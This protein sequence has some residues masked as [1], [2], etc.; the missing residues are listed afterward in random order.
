MYQVK[1]LVQREGLASSSHLLDLTQAMERK[2]TVKRAKEFLE[3]LVTEHWLSVVS[4][5]WNPSLP[6]RDT[7]TLNSLYS[8]HTPLKFSGQWCSGQ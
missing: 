8:D 1:L 7:H 3:T 4:F 5:N 6:P 2:Y